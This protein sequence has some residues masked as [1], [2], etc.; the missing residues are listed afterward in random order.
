M[1]GDQD[2]HS[3]N[4]RMSEDRER[5]RRDVGHDKQQSGIDQSRNYGRQEEVKARVKSSLEKMENAIN[6]IRSELEKNI[7]NRVE[8]VRRLPTKSARPSARN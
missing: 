8:D 6:S 7:K 3:H 2:G 5:S 4:R 1:N